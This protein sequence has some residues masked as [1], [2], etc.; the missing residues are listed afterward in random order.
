MKVSTIPIIFWQTYVKKLYSRPERAEKCVE[1]FLI[2]S[3]TMLL[4]RIDDILRD[5]FEIF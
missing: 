4:R 2:S 1:N 3:D 5:S